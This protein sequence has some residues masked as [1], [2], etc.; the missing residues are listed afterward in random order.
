MSSHADVERDLS[1]ESSQRELST[2]SLSTSACSPSDASWHSA[3]AASATYHHELVTRLRDTIRSSPTCPVIATHRRVA[4]V[5]AS[6]GATSNLVQ[7]SSPQ[8]RPLMSPSSSEVL[9]NTSI[10]SNVLAFPADTRGT[11]GAADKSLS[12]VHTKLFINEDSI[13]GD[14]NGIS[15]LDDIRT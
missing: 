10:Q 7:L 5:H 13:A 6:P 2:D 8:R 11:P 14:P 3:L 15:F 1:P 9:A 4:N 12:H